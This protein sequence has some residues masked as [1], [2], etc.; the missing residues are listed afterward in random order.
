MREPYKDILVLLLVSVLLSVT[1]VLPLLI[2][3]FIDRLEW[4]DYEYDRG[5]TCETVQCGNVRGARVDTNLW[6]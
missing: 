5:G 3:D 1:L 4:R 6:P 2:V